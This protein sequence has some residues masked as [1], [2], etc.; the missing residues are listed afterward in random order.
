VIVVTAD[1]DSETAIEAMQLGAYDYLF[2]P[3]DLPQVN[4]LV[5]ACHQLASVDESPCGVGG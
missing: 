4:R 3:L 1:S 2:K 5:Q